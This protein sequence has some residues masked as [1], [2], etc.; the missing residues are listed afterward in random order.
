VANQ[1]RLAKNPFTCPH[2]RPTLIRFSKEDLDGMFK[3]T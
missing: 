1:L 3:R 2:G